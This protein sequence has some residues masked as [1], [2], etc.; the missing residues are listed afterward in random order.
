MKKLRQAI[1]VLEDGV[2]TE[3]ETYKTQIS[4]IEHW[5]KE[6]RDLKVFHSKYSSKKHLQ[7]ENTQSNQLHPPLNKHPFVFGG[8]FIYKQPDRNNK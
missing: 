6:I 8:G 3:R 2:K 1:E 4:E 5:E 7:S